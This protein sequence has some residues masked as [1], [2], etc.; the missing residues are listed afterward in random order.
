M[1]SN[2]TT[3]SGASHN[4]DSSHRTRN[5]IISAG[6]GAVIIVVCL[7]FCPF[8]FMSA[9]AQTIVRIPRNATPEMLTDTLTRHFD[10]D[11]ASKVMKV[12]S[13]FGADLKERHGA[14]TIEEGMSPLQAGKLLARGQQTPVKLTIN[15]FRT[16]DTLADRISR[17]FEFSKS[18]LLAVL[19]DSTR[20]AR[21]GLTPDQAISLFIDDT[22]YV[23]WDATPADIISKVGQNYDRVWNSERTAKAKALGIT[24][25]QAMIICSIADEETQKS[26]EK[27]TITRLY[28]NRL[29]K[30]M[31]LQADPTVRYALN[32]FTIKRVTSAMLG[33]DSPYNTYRYEGLPPGPIRTTSVK[34]IDA[35]LDSEPNPYF[36]MCAKEDF[37]GYHNFAETFEEHKENARRYQQKLN[38]LGIK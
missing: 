6:I 28:L 38:E 18:D 9:K 34:T 3:R 25:A 20:L 12:F 23:Y 21:Y 8:V 22:Y 15:G 5:I 26:D 17:K 19:S 2:R 24:P 32:D 11:Y 14:Y 4:S 13:T 35:L 36:Y 10:A 31:K 27:G 30:G 1:P 33:T 37:S 29:K 16:L 7:L